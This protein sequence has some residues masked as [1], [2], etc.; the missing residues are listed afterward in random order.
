KDERELE[1]YLIR[2]ASESRTVELADGRSIAGEALER[3]LEQLMA[4]RKLLQV[5]ERRVPLR[6]AVLE[7]L[8]R[9]ARDLSFWSQRTAVEALAEALRAPSVRATV[10]DDVEHQAHAIDVDD[11]ESG[12]SRRYRLGLDFVTAGEFR[13]LATAYPGVKDL[14]A[15]PVTIRTAASGVA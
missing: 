15:G 11:G 8:R 4:F 14:I 10:V 5:V 12:Y 9:E 1:T 7:L 6:R 13:T 3:Q 2:R